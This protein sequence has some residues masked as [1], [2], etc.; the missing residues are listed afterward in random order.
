MIPKKKIEIFDPNL[1][2]QYLKSKVIDVVHYLGL[3]LE[4]K[5]NLL[6]GCCPI[7]GGDNMTAFNIQLSGSYAG[8]TYCNTGDCNKGG[9][10][11]IS[12]V[13]RVKNVNFGTAMK[14]CASIIGNEHSDKLSSPSSFYQ[15][16]S[17]PIIKPP[18]VKLKGTATR[19]TVR[20]LL[21]IPSPY[22]LSRGFDAQLLDEYDV[23]DCWVVGN[24]MRGRAVFPVYDDEYLCVGAVGR[25]I[26]DTWM[27]A[28]W[29]NSK[30]FKSS[31][32]FYG[33]WNYT[34]TSRAII[35]EGQGDILKLRHAGYGDSLGMFK[36]RL[37]DDQIQILIELGVKDLLVITDR[38]KA[39]EEGYESIK[40]KANM[41]NISR[42][43]PKGKDI[44]EMD[45]EV[46]RKLCL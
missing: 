30:G 34:K 5:G 19:N 24:R 35:V 37:T 14:I 28:K 44:G 36:N 41:F 39:G 46:V 25:K 42:F 3:N 11:L 4:R 1:V 2:K 40:A 16:T 7:H 38:D 18:F 10:D 26:S 27:T 22:Y 31:Q 13:M 33:Q 17:A 20:N 23:G 43:I 6:V 8:T 29:K 15:H 45:V 21:H 12:L 9:T 32:I